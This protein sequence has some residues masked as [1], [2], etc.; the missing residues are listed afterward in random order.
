MAS[1]SSN[2][3]LKFFTEICIGN[4]AESASWKPA[5]VK[6]AEQLVNTKHG[7]ARKLA[8]LGILRAPRMLTS[9]D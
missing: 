6:T 9:N 7:S 4:H 2:I 1:R 5:L 3:P 8:H